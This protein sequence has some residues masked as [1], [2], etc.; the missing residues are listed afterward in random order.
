M[1]SLARGM[2][3]WWAFVKTVIYINPCTELNLEK[4]KEKKNHSGWCVISFTNRT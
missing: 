2:D 3:K 1:I 4:K